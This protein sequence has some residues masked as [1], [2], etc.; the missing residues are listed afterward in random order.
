MPLRIAQPTSRQERDVTDELFEVPL[1][2]LNVVLFPG[3]ALPLHVFEP[4]YRQMVESCLDD[5]APFGVVLS[6]P[7][8]AIEHEVPA[9]VGTLARIV[10]CAKLPDGRYNLLAMGTRRFE[11]VEQ[12]H[13]KAYLT[14]LVRPFLDRADAAEGGSRVLVG[15]AQTALAEYLGVVLSLVGSE[16]RHIEIPS[17]AEDL[18]FLIGMCLACEDHDKQD[19]LEMTSVAKRLRVGTVMLREETAALS[20]Q[21][22]TGA[23]SRANNDTARSDR[24]LLN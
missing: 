3:M 5:Q 11:I 6:L 13:Q 16:Q 4:R 9:R 2:P 18:S 24:S 17:D 15:D 12:R 10:D 20:R 21:I 19:L 1:F 7:D 22:E 23:S 8:S 14:G